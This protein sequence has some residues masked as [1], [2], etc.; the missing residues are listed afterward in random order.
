LIPLVHGEPVRFGDQVVTRDV[1]V[2]PADEVT[3][4]DVL[5][6]DVAAD[7][8]IP[9]A[10][11]RL[12]DPTTLATTPV[13]VFRDVERPVYDDMMNAQLTDD[14]DLSALLH[15]RDSWTVA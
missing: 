6:H 11:S 7:V 5:V 2:R 12:S 14:G 9:F 1:R 15:G 8:A 4:E 13:G 10:L 3:D